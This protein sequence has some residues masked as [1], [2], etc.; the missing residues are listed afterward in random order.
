MAGFDMSDRTIPLSVSTD[1]ICGH[2]IRHTQTLMM[3]AEEASE[4]Q[5]DNFILA[6]LIS[7]EVFIT[8]ST[9]FRPLN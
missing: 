7:R 8:F 4:T 9:L 2:D 6:R 3:E 5:D 1:K